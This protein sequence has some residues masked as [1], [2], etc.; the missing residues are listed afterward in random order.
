MRKAIFCSLLLTAAVPVYG[1]QRPPAQPTEQKVE[2]FTDE[3]KRQ[4]L[5]ALKTIADSFGTAPQTAPQAQAQQAAPQK[6]M[7]D[8]ADKALEISTKY[9]GQVAAILEK[10]APQVWRVMVMQQ[11][12]KAFGELSGPLTLF[13][14]TWVTAF[15]T[16]RFWKLDED[17]HEDE[18]NWRIALTMFAPAVLMF[19]S[20]ATFGWRLSDSIMYLINPEY[21]AIKDLLSMLLKGGVM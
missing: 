13:F 6:S 10:A 16:R 19:I 17:A 20:F 15:T 11:Y 3:E 8:V 18:M 9:I 21:Y 2:A 1:D 14:L 7:A 4:A 5:E 12:A